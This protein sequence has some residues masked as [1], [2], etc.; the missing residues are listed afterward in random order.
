MPHFRKGSQNQKAAPVSEAAR[1]RRVWREFQGSRCK[2]S[3]CRAERKRSFDTW[4]RENI[5]AIASLVVSLNSIL[6][7]KCVAICNRGCFPKATSYVSET[8]PLDPPCFEQFPRNCA[9]CAL[10]E[11]V[12]PAF[13]FKAVRFNMGIANPFKKRSFSSPEASLGFG[14]RSV[15]RL[16]S[17]CS[18][19]L[20][21]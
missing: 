19:K 5:W 12:E 15:L 2:G 16:L 9:G 4:K 11:E 17:A 21:S 3:F 10:G 6:K 20:C 14:Q 18:V 7:A 8:Y 1:K 13:H